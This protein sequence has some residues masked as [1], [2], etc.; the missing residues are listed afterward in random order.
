MSDNISRADAIEELDEYFEHIKIIDKRGLKR[1]EPISRD[2]KGIVDA[3]P[4]AEAGQGWNNHEVACML[5][6]LFGDTCACN[7]NSIDE[8]LPLVCDFKDI[9]PNTVGVA[10]WEQFLKNYRE[11]EKTMKAEQLESADRPH[12]E[13]KHNKTYSSMDFCSECGMPFLHEDKYPRNYCP[14]CGT[15]MDKGGDRE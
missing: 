15:K 8:W 6:E 1:I 10:C 12:G 13:W 4:S 7:Y 9:C 14:N 11:K 5:A 2:V 3:L